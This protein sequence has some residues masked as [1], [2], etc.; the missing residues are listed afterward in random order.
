MTEVKKKKS[1]PLYIKILLGVVLGV[2]WGVLSKYL[3]IP[4]SFTNNYIQPFGAIFLNLLKLIAVPLILASL[5]VGVA[6][7]GDIRKLSRMGGKT[8]GIYLLTTLIALVIGLGVVNVIRPGV[9]I[10]QETRDK[11]MEG[12]KQS[13]S[14]KL[15]I[16]AKNKEKGPLAPLVDMFPDNITKAATDNKNMLQVV[17]FALIVGIAAVSLPKEQTATFVA[18]FD[19]LN[20]IILK[21]IDYIMLYAP[22]GV[23]ALMAKLIADAPNAEILWALG[24]YCLSLIIGLLVMMLGVYPTIM[25]M[26][27]KLGY[28]DF[29]RALRPAQLLAFSSSSSAATLPL[30]MKRCEENLGVSEEV[31]SFVLPLGATINMDG[32][33]MYQA[34]AAVF[35]SQ[36]IGDDLTLG[37]QLTIVLTALLASIGTAGVPGVGVI[38]LAI[39]LE[40]VGIPLEYIA[41][42]LAPDRI[43]D[44]CR[45]VVNVTG[46]AAVAATVAAT[47]GQLTPVSEEVEDL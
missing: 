25:M 35:I 39:V 43:L 20:N 45:T 12:S 7:L 9:G 31:S 10:S 30:T 23:F 34:V 37:E 14:D 22:I 36:V 17:V 4:E 32:T 41:L 3:G 40:S 28:M 47:E 21:V 46:D 8:I 1:I 6:N 42:I 15:E 18:F 16:V 11:L 38:M 27:S 2:L 44:M 5:I 29:F 26:V 33:S 24:W 13:A 19:N